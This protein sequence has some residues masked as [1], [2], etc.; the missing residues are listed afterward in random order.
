MSTPALIEE[1]PAAIAEAPAIDDLFHAMCRA[2]ASD[3]H[4][5]VGTP[6]LVRKD[7]RMQLLD[8]HVPPLTDELLAHLLDPITPAD[9]RRE[10]AE[11]HDTDFAYEI[12]GLARFR[13]N[14]FADRKGRGAVFRVIP[15]NILTAEQLGLSPFILNL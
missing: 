11:R 3:L 12:P 13:A 10:F 8:P 5:C 4:L 7:G 6:P 9:N 2:G 1:A 15:T 14:V